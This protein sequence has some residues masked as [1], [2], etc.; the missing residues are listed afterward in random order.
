MIHPHDFVHVNLLLLLETFLSADV[1][2]VAE[3]LIDFLRQV[4]RLV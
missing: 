2:A 4:V 1:L 3:L